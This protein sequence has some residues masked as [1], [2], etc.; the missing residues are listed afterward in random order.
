MLKFFFRQDNAIFPSN[1]RSENG[2]LYIEYAIPENQGVY[3][4]QSPLSD[5]APV[6]ILVTVNVQSPPTPGVYNITVSEDRLRIPTGGSGTVECNVDGRPAPLIRWTKV[7][8]ISTAHFSPN[9]LRDYHCYTHHYI[10]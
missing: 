6:P 5:V 8:T 7:K 3:V 10:V 4:C 9:Y 2:V 1:V